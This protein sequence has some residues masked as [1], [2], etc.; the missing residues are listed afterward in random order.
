MASNTVDIYIKGH[1]KDL[2]RAIDRVKASLASI[3]N[4]TAKVT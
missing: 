3:R 4:T 1:E 2:L